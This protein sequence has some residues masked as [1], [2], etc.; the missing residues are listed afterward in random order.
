LRYRL[1]R[2][3]E[4]QPGAELSRAAKQRLRW[5]DYARTHSVAQTCRHCGIARSTFYRWRKRY[6][7]KNLATLEDR[8]ARPKRCRR[9][10]WTVSQ[11]EAVRPARE[12]HPRWGK[13]KLAVVL[14][15]DGVHLSVSMI[16]RILADLKRRQVLA[17]PRRTRC[18]SPRSTPSNAPAIWSSS[19]PC[20]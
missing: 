7:P 14:K 10:T 5:L 18:A 6:D 3:A 8:P 17:E 9:P 12:A 16:G 19:I 13:D 20:T 4:R 11:A 15:R 1:P 2:Q